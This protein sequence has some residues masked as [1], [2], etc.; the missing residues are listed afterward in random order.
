MLLH[1]IG[2]LRRTHQAVHR[3]IGEIRRGD[4]LLVARC[5]RGNS[6]EHGDDLD[7]D[8]RS[9]SLRRDLKLLTASP[10]DGLSGCGLNRPPG[11]KM[12]SYVARASRMR[13][14]RSRSDFEKNE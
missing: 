12:L 7:H 2:E 3:D 14:A 10:S 1:P 13:R 11:G 5:W 9:A 6:T 8:V 4:D